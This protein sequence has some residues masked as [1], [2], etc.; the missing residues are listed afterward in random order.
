MLRGKSDAQRI[1]A[2]KE[3]PSRKLL[4]FQLTIACVVLLHGNEVGSKQHNGQQSSK[5]AQYYILSIGSTTTSTGRT[6]HMIVAATCVPTPLLVYT[7]TCRIEPYT[8]I[9]IT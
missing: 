2:L 9:T 1:N 3:T 7:T 5:S 4:K 6:I 8:I